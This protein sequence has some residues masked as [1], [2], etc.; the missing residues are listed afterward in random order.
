MES[1]ANN[2]QSG[3]LRK[4]RA[5]LG[6]LPPAIGGERLPLVRVLVGW[7]PQNFDS[8]DERARSVNDRI[9][10]DGS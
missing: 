7:K 3:D 5:L 1:V 2:A 8:K 9:L 4:C 6:D 10:Q